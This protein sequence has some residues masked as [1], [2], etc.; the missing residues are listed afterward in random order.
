[1]IDSDSK[2]INPYPS[3][4]LQSFKYCKGKNSNLV[5]LENPKVK[6][7]KAH[8]GFIAFTKLGIQFEIFNINFYS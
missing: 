4:S 6:E 7:T 2:F 3:S 1:M 8:T 5:R